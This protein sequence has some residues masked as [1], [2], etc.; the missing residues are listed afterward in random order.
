MFCGFVFPA[1]RFSVSLAMVLAVWLMLLSD[2][3]D[4][5]LKLPSS[6]QSATKRAKKKKKQTLADLGKNRVT[7]KFRIKGKNYYGLPLAYDGKTLAL[8]RWDGRVSK[9]AAKRDTQVEIIDQNFLPYTHDEL[10]PRLKKEFGDRYSISKT[11]HYVV[12]HPQGSREIWAEPFEN[13]Y[14][15]FRHWF[16]DHGLE[17]AEPQFPLIAV[18]LRSRRDFDRFMDKELDVRNRAVQGFYSQRTNRMVMFDPSAMLRIEDQTWLYRDPTI[19]HEATHQTAF[20]TGVHQRFS[21]PPTWLAEGLAMLF[22][23]PGYN[24]SRQFTT[25]KH[26]VNRKRLS[27]LKKLGTVSEVSSQMIDLIGDDTLLRTKPYD[28]YTLSWG[29]TW[30]LAETRTE[31]FVAYLKR[32]ARRQNYAR[33]TQADHIRSFVKVFGNDLEALQADL[34]AFY[35]TRW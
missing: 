11:K 23:T 29:L 16:V 13:L 10:I 35:Q 25:A 34:E 18:V 24:R 22:E 7:M 15:Q 30:F 9:L 2:T 33:W 8:L 28:Y 6:S 4:A 26:R 1:T 12:V 32:D 20:N 19:V 31:R 17:P 3:A 21:P 5:Q 14:I 27:E